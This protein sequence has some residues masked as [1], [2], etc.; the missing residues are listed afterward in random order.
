[1]GR[2][3]YRHHGA[4]ADGGAHPAR[5]SD[6]SRSVSPR[7]PPPERDDVAFDAT[8]VPAGQ[9]ALVGGDWYDAFSLPDGRIVLSIG[10]VAGHGL[11]AA[12]DAGRLRQVIFS[13]ALDST[14]PAGVLA[15]ADKVL[16]AQGDTIATAL[17]AFYNPVDATVTHASAGHPMPIVSTATGVTRL[18][19]GVGAPL[20][21]GFIDGALSVPTN[22]VAL[23][24][25]SLL[26]LYTDGITEFRRDP[27][28]GEAR[29]L[30]VVARLAD[31]STERPASTLLQDIAGDLAPS[32]DIAILVMRRSTEVG[33]LQPKAA[34]VT[35]TWR[36]HSSHAYSAR[37]SRLELVACLR[38]HARRPK[39]SS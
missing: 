9:E 11:S 24:D 35:K 15:K 29:L 1:M 13:E 14:D 5:R 38:D 20:G 2:N 3:E 6:H 34:H 28:G 4:Q 37:A 18:L 16:R 39:T 8:Y 27:L 36:F 30:E 23:E 25:D 12:V 22:V 17:V 7:A 33:K 31:R 21:T 19:S 32:D 10:D 26:V